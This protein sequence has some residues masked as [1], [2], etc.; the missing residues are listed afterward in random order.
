LFNNFVFGGQSGGGRTCRRTI[1]RPDCFGGATNRYSGSRFGPRP[2]LT[3]GRQIV[4]APSPAAPDLPPN[5]PPYINS[6]GPPSKTISSLHLLPHAR[7]HLHGRS[8]L[9]LLLL[10]VP[11][12]NQTSPNLDRVEIGD[13]EAFHQRVSRFI[14]RIGRS[15]LVLLSKC[16]MSS[17]IP[18]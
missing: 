5:R 15:G 2:K 13:L 7:S 9:K 11:P 17:G 8:P 16:T 18:F 6:W 1:Q 12:P 4:P 3:G 14:D 10:L